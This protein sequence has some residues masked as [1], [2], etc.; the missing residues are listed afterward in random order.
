MRWG[1]IPILFS[2]ASATYAAPPSA[3]SLAGDWAVI[4]G[5]TPLL[6]LHLDPTSS[7]LGGTV[8]SPK[9]FTF[10]ANQ[11]FSGFEGPTIVQR[12]ERA[13]PVGDAW[14]LTMPLR[15]EDEKPT[16]L[17][18]RRDAGGK[19]QL[20]WKG[21]PVEEVPLERAGPGTRLPESWAKGRTYYVE[22]DHPT[23]AEMT[24]LFKA[25][26]ADRSTGIGAIDW[27]KVEPRDAAR[28][29]RTKTLLDQGALASGDD[30][31]H[32]AFIFQHGSDA[33]SYLLAHVLATTAVARGRRNA[34]WIAAATLDRYLQ[35]IGQKQIYGTQFATPP[36]GGGATTQEPY[37]RS[38]ISDALRKV[39]GVPSQARQ[40][41]TRADFE[42]RFRARKPASTKP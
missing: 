30:F 32:A 6:L 40:E 39:A 22:V 34:A 12:I 3:S 10:S 31:Y 24:A 17:T 25:D 16:V 37:D 41:K 29:L 21:V 8:T 11:A 4:A 26:Q 9:T 20:G 42:A 2:V 27:A 5:N 23:N 1:L 33:Q 35:E 36:D 15:R 19:T 38:L 14:E 28:R 13:I 7:G 18:L